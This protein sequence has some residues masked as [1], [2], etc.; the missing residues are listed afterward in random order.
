[1]F[2]RH[3]HCRGPVAAV[4]AGLEGTL[5]REALRIELYLQNQLETAKLETC[6]YVLLLF[7]EQGGTLDEEDAPR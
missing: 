2:L 3:A 1:M 5:R 6:E 7:G 4:D